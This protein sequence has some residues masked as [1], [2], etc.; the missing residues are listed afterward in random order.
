[1]DLSFSTANARYAFGQFDRVSIDN[2]PS[3]SKWK[4]KPATFSAGTTRVGFVSNSRTQIS[5]VSVS[6]AVFGSNATTSI[7]LQHING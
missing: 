3:K 7:R 4:P 2:L 1:M 5:H 6:R